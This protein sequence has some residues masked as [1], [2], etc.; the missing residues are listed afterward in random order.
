MFAIFEQKSQNIFIWEDITGIMFKKIVFWCEFPETVDWKKAES[1]IKGIP[2]EVYVA[3]KSVKEYKRYKIKTELPI[4]PWPVLSKKEGYW[5]SGFTSKKSIDKLK[6]F[7]GIKIKVDLEPP[8][9]KWKYGTV[10]I[11]LYAMRK[12]FQKGKN[13]EYLRRV[14]YETAGKGSGIV[15]KNINMIINEFPFARW[16]LKNQG[17]YL[18][19]KESMNKNYMCYTTFAGS[20]FRP[21][22]RFYLKPFTKLAVKR[23][24]DVMFSIGLIG[25]GILEREGTYRN[26][27]QFTEDLKMVKES[28]V[29]QVAIYSLEG[30]LKRKN[31]EEWVRAV[32]EFVSR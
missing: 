20:F 18:E 26:V 8:I 32:K 30:I 14:I 27:K 15:T 28:G 5:F 29:K 6:Q 4:Y 2:S 24:K 7:K 23:N 19:L 9:P 21:F 3:V 31:P 12:I 1:L 17:T 22:I 16:Y 11:I 13:N 25:T 10:K